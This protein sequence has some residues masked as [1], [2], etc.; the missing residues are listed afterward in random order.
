MSMFKIC[1]VRVVDEVGVHYYLFWTGRWLV[2]DFTNLK[3]E[4]VIDLELSWTHVTYLGDL[5]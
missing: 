3:V 5:Q 4:V 2:L 1:L